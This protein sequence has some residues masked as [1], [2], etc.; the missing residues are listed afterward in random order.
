M[1]LGRSNN[2]MFSEKAIAKAKAR[3]LDSDLYDQDNRGGAFIDESMTVSGAVN[4]TMIL[5]LVLMCTAFY[6]F[7]TPMPIFLPVGALG[8]AAVFMFTSFKPQ[9]SSITAPL[10]AVLEGLFVGT[11]SA[12]YAAQFEGIIF[13]ALS[14]TIGVLLT[15]LMVYKSG[16]IQVTQKFRMGV[17]MAV[18]AIMILYLVSWIGSFVGFQIPYLHEGGAIGIGITVVIIGIAALNLLLDFDNFDKGEQAGAPKFMEWYFGMGLLFTLVWLY[19]EF[20]RL[21]SKLQRD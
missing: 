3:T 13:Q 4:K 2:P 17:S 1:K 10:F 11:V 19:V 20:L 12:V 7:A 9:Y 14:A 21:I 15:M 5:T 6:S 8:A 16:L 18:G